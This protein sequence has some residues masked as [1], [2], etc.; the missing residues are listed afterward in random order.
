ME[1]LSREIHALYFIRAVENLG[2][3]SE[4]RSKHTGPRDIRW[5]HS[6]LSCTLFLHVSPPPPESFLE[7]RVYPMYISSFSIAVLERHDPGS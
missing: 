2:D 6:P 3:R 7:A 4:I 5:W 1:T